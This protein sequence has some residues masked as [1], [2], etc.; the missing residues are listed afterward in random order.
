MFIIMKLPSRRLLFLALAILL[1]VGII[2][3]AWRTV[4]FQDDSLESEGIGTGT[5]NENGSWR[6]ALKVIPQ[7]SLTRLL[8]ANAGN[9]SSTVATTTTDILGR[10]LLTSYALAQKSIGDTPMT[11][12][13]A[14]AISDI[15]AG[16]VMDDTMVKTYTEKDL[17]IVATNNSS[18]NTY[19]KALATALGNFSRKNTADELK[20]VLDAVE[21]RDAAKLAPLAGTVKNLQTLVDAL[22]AM[23]VPRDTAVLHIFFLNNYTLILSGV[24][25]MQRIVD[26]P[27]LGMRGVA[28]YQEGM[29][30]ITRFAELMKTGR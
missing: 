24:T 7:D 18:L 27:A 11:D 6:E 26:D 2:F 14:K 1:G 8:G 20:I 19:Q 23:K 29:N 17:I 15:L 5:L 9:A 28:K 22:L 30:A 12:A 3:F 21:K 25:D 16:K 4:S 10:E 13:D